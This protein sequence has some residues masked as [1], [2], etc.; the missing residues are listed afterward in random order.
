[1]EGQS[2]Q[3]QIA[4]TLPT[5]IAKVNEHAPASSLWSRFFFPAGPTAPPASSRNN[6]SSL[7]LLL[8]LASVLF[9]MRLKAPLLEPQEPR[10]AEIARQMLAESRLLVPVLHGEDYLDK[11]PLLYWLIMASYRIFGV[12]DWAARI[13]P[14][15]VGVLIVLTVYLWGRRTVGERAA[16]WGALVLCLSARF[17]YLGRMLV[18]D[19]LLTLCVTAALALAH[20]ALTSERGLRNSLWLLSALACA[21]GV[22]TKG[23]VALVLVLVPLILFAL[24][25]RRRAAVSWW[26]WLVYLGVAVGL[27][28]PW[29]VFIAAQVPGFAEDF[30][31]RHHIVRFVQPF[32]HPGPPWFYLPGVLLGLLPWTLLLP[33]LVY[34][35]CR[36]SVRRPSAVGFFVLAFLT[37]F[38]FFSASG[39]KRAVYI[40]PALPP[41]ALALGWYLARVIQCTEGRLWWPA[42]R[43]PALAGMATLLVLTLGLGTVIAAGVNHLLRPGLA[44]MLIACALLAIAA[45]GSL[46]RGLTWRACAVVTFLVLAVGVQYLLPAYNRQFAL[47]GDLQANAAWRDRPSIPVV[48]YPQRYDSVSFYL[49]HANVR[50]FTLNQRAELL[51]SLRDHPETLLL[52]KSG[53]LLQELLDELPGS[54]VFVTSGKPQGAVTVGWVRNRAEPPAVLTAER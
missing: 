41:L 10:Y 25:E 4:L 3:G 52:I 7:A 51:A 28:A 11:P 53:R 47:R 15:L 44:L 22:L 42:L 9:F 16:F 12:H 13:V 21:L 46:R 19:G 33:G 24:L 43:R 34:S 48:C 8:A 45:V 30:F 29:F 31:W 2:I 36:R 40:L 39:C 35:L 50:V 37:A 54:M 6:W 17:V 38:A 32:D 26:A 18:M 23:P 5:G 49:P 20:V 1:M 14:G 27:A